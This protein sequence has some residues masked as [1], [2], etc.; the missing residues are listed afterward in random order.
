MS[1]LEDVITLDEAAEISGRAPV[2]LRAAAAR[3]RLEAKRVGQGPG[4][5]WITTRD[6]IAYY[7]ADVASRHPESV[8]QHL[9]RPGGHARHGRRRRIRSGA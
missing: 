4:A 2:S 8:P 1:A 3:G 9:R 5:V 6:A 7:M